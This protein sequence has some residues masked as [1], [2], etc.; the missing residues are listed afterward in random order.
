MKTTIKGD[1]QICVSVPLVGGWIVWPL[2]IQHE[3]K[4]QTK[5][6]DISETQQV[7]VKFNSR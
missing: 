5:Y 4:N 3:E 7:S 2:V 1:F 6:W